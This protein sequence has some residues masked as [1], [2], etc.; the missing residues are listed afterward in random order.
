MLFHCCFI[1]IFHNLL[2]TRTENFIWKCNNCC[3]NYRLHYTSRMHRKWKIKVKAAKMITGKS[4]KSM[5]KML[6][7]IYSSNCFH[8]T[9]APPYIMKRKW[10]IILCIPI[11]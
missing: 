9:F 5:S 10:K 1:F 7:H 3:C 6:Y 2:S 8:I 4:N 11:T